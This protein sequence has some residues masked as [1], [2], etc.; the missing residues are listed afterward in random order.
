MWLEALDWTLGDPDLTAQGEAQL[1]EFL[2]TSHKLLAQAQEGDGYLD[3]HFQVRFPGERFQQLPWGH[4]LY[5]A[6]H[7]IQSAVALHR[8]RYDA[9]LLD[10]ARRVA[11]PG[12]WSCQ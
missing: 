5:C 6:G 7:L 3:S 12:R 10:V 4:E 9:R 11:D 1:Q 2:E 8:T